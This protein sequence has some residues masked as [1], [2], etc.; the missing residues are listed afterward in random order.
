MLWY[1]PCYSN[2]QVAFDQGYS[3]LNGSSW[4]KRE[5]RRRRK[6]EARRR[7]SECKGAEV[8]RMDDKGKV[9]R[10]HPDRAIDKGV[11]EWKMDEFLA[12][13]R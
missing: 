13:R 3:S 4:C 1:I 12:F 11:Y 2:V 7:I 8:C 10:L 5:V 9:R 6:S